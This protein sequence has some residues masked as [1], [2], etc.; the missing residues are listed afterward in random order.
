MVGT[1]IKQSTILVGAGLDQSTADMSYITNPKDGSTILTNTQ[2]MT[3]DDIP[4][5]SM[6]A[7]W[8]ICRQKKIALDFLTDEDSVETVI[9]TMVEAIVEDI[10]ENLPD[11]G[12][13]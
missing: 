9:N 5:W 7:L 12:D 8:E 11:A 10:K 1:T 3:K 13:E 2:V 6:G 4:C